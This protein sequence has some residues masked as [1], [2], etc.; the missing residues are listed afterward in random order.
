MANIYI[1]RIEKVSNITYSRQT[2]L[3]YC[4]VSIYSKVY[5]RGFD[6]MFDM[7]ILSCLDRFKSDFTTA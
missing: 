5:K 7:V 6:E 2:E 3:Y 4:K 1:E